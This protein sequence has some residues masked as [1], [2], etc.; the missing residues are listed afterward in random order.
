MKTVKIKLTGEAEDVLSMTK[1]LESVF[2]I[3]AIA[4]MSG[5][6]QGDE[7]FIRYID[8]IT[9]HPEAIFEDANKNPVR[10][11]LI[12]LIKKEGRAQ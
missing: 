10:G 6:F 8:V 3:E 1:K 5:I 7:V 12:K 9:E 4:Q 11:S 2:G